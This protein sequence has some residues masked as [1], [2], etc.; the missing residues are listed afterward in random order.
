M[1]EKDAIKTYDN[2]LKNKTSGVKV[3]LSTNTG[4]KPFIKQLKNFNS[5]WGNCQFF[6]NEDIEKCDLWVIYGGLKQS[7]S[8]LCS[9]DNTL[10]ITAEP[11]SIRRYSR[12]FINQFGAILTCQKNMQHPN[13][14]LRQQALPWWV[15]HKINN[16]KDT[17]EYSKTYDELKSIKNINKTKNISVIV[18]NKKFTKGHKKRL[19]FINKLKESF[20]NDIDIFG[21][22]FNEIDDKWDAIAPYKYHIVLENSSLDDYWTEKLSDAFL[23]MAYP[24]YYGCKN[25]YDYFPTDSMSII[26]IS[27]PDQAMEKIKSIIKNNIYEKSTESLR[28]SKDLILDEYQLFPMLVKYANENLVEINKKTPIT[29]YSETNNSIISIIRKGL[30]FIKKLV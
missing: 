5:V 22:G 19:S 30:K 27:N 1:Q 6:I 8:T 26:D 25:I 12:K 21:I 23:G 16:E 20:G 24:I 17:R 15:G 7:E 13:L 4:G 9:K 14:I 2:S 28:R 29:I 3:K 11:P 10:F 18:S